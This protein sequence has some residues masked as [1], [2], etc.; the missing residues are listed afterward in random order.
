MIP[1]VGDERAK[2]TTPL[3]SIPAAQAVK[4]TTLYV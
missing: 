1:P 2:V 3:G 4:G